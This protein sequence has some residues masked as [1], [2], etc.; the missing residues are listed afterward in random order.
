MYLF[1][2]LDICLHINVYIYIYD[3]EIRGGKVNN[4]YE[5]QKKTR[6][7]EVEKLLLKGGKNVCLET[8]V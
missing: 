2:D 6:K 4:V 7:I 8:N 1:S 5:G 3:K